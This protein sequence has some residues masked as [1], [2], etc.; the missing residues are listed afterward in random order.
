MIV[1]STDGVEIA[2]HDLGGTGPPLLISHATGFH[3]RCYEPLAHALADRFH[4]VAFDYRGH[5]DTP[6][7]DGPV[8]WQRYG[9]DAE[10]MAVWL[11]EQQRRPTD[12]RVRA[13]DGRRLPADGRAPRPDAVPPARAVRADR[14]PAAG[15][16]PADA[17]GATDSPMVDRRPPAAV[18]VPL[19]RGRHRQ[20]RVQAAAQRLHAG[21]AARLRAARLRPRR[22]RRAPEVPARDRG[23]DVRD[24]RPHTTRGTS[25]PRSTPTCS[26]WP[27]GWRRSQPSRIAAEVAERLPNGRYLQLDAARPLRPDDP[28][29]RWSPTSSPQDARR[30]LT[31][32]RRRTLGWCTTLRAPLLYDDGMYPVPTSLSP[33]RVESFLVLPDGVPLR[34]HR[35]AARA[36]QPCTPPRVRWCTVRSSCC[37][38]GPTPSAR[39][40]P[41]Q[42]AFDQAVA[43]YRRRPR[44]HPARAR[45]RQRPTRSSPTAGRWSRPT[46]RWRTPPRCATSGSSCASR[47]RSASL[48]LRGIIDRL[49]LDAEGS[50][51]VTDYKTGR[52][53]GAQLRAE[54]PRRRALLLVPVRAR[55]SASGPRPSG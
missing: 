44:V 8:D 29:R 37:S 33:S 1:P 46:S 36:A 27:A 20:L 45:R 2:V 24:R 31:V 17:A 19:V 50:L 14:V 30:E 12:R 26:S 6:Q 16:P 18:D 3:G 41:P 28:P 40:R 15:R 9:D 39:S 38:C 10:A 7:P 13:L 4:S 22:R 51:V 49:E 43:E 32:S 5:G 25:C 34:Q 23:R 53:P 11:V 54:P 48:T 55:C 42:L 35:E 47:P 52:P 21:G